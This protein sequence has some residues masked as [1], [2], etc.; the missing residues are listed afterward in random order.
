[1]NG[2]L[3][4]ILSIHRECI[5]GSVLILTIVERKE[6]LCP[7]VPASCVHACLHACLPASLQSIDKKSNGSQS[8][9]GQ[10][11]DVLD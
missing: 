11:Y 5:V 2:I 7:C 6:K 9:G 10:I 3:M 4:C 8:H 1:M